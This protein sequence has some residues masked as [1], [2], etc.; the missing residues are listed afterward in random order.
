MECKL[1]IKVI[2]ATM[3]LLENSGPDEIEPDTAVQ[4]LEAIGYELLQLA[5][6]DRS[7]FI[8]VINEIASSERDEGVSKFT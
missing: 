6:Q 1:V 3:A 4:G 7:K 8:A 5:D 2:V